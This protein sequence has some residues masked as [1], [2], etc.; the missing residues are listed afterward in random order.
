LCADGGRTARAFLGADLIDEMVIA[1]V[2]VLL[3]NGIPV[4]AALD[5]ELELRHLETTTLAMDLAQS[6]YQ[7]AWH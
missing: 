7:R 6:P 5:H 2:P 1:D 4:F 3:A